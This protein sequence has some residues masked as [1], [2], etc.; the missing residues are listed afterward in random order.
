MFKK[1]KKCSKNEKLLLQ[2]ADDVHE[3]EVERSV[4]RWVERSDAA[5]I[6]KGS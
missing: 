4:E 5:V 2:L 3:D 6:S 1:R